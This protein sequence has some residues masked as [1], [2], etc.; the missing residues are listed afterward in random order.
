MKTLY[1]VIINIYIVW[2]RFYRFFERHM[3]GYKK[4][5]TEFLK[6]IENFNTETKWNIVLKTICYEHDKPYQLWDVTS[7]PFHVLR[8]GWGDCDD[9]SAI[10]FSV[11]G[12]EIEY[13]NKKYR[14]SGTFYLIRKSGGHVISL[15]KNTLG[16]DFLMI[17]TKQLTIQKDLKTAF[18]CFENVK[19]IAY[20]FAHN[21]KEHFDIKFKKIVM[22]KNFETFYKEGL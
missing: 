22:Q 9:Y 17:S 14:Y 4:F 5:K 7:D 3:P 15:W 2:S 12:Y 18:K 21:G 16:K 11:L 19:A 20:V 10:A 6:A 13:R 1:T 8:R